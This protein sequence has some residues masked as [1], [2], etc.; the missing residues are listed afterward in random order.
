MQATWMVRGVSAE[1]RRKAKA[2]AAAEG[3]KI[4]AWI[5]SAIDARSAD[6]EQRRENAKWYAEH[7][8]E[9]PENMGEKRQIFEYDVGPGK[10]ELRKVEEPPK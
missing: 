8:V 4:G 7:A 5:E 9:K 1:H 3:V 2:A 6:D 10:R